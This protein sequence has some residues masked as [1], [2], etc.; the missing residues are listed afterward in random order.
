MKANRSLFAII[1]KTHTHTHTHTHMWKK[2]LGN[3]I[4]NRKLM[5]AR[6]K[7]RKKEKKK[8]K[9]Q[10]EKCENYMLMI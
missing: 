5:V 7:G 8:C 1:N 10:T 9:M 6:W 4:G 3:S 2:L